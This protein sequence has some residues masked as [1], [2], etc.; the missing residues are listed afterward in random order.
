[1]NGITPTRRQLSKRLPRPLPARWATGTLLALVLLGPG[2]MLE[3]TAA[4]ADGIDAISNHDAAGGLR[5]ALSQGIHN[6]VSKLGADGGFLN[7]PRVTIPL[8]GALEKADKALRMVGMSGEADQLKQTM[9]H[10]A[11][12]AVR[13][14][15]PVLMKSLK[16]MSLSDAKGILTGGET[17]ATDYFRRTS[18]DELKQT[19]K[20]IVAQATQ[21]VKLADQYD[22]LA[23][24]AA[25]FGLLKGDEASMNDYVTAR[26]L[27]GLFVVMADEERAIRKDPLG[28]ASSLIKKVFGSL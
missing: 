11:E 7:D 28:Q 13:N 15:T 3:S 20:P 17:S 1:M 24:K 8:P 5:A 16:N 23:S 25:E 27:D 26:T 9:N 4:T 18:S 21:H 19:F 6:S 22:K 10:A 14:A 2:L 12:L